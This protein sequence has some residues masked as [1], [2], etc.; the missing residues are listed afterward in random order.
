MSEMFLPRY[1]DE[2]V[3]VDIQ[4][5]DNG[6][7]KG[8][9]LELHDKDGKKVRGDFIPAGNLLLEYDDLLIEREKEE[10]EV[11][12]IKKKEQAGMA[13]DKEELLTLMNYR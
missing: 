4:T 12:A 11:E 13:L 10:D 6:E 9:Y 5:Y 7:I 1:N 3:Y 8:V 2:T